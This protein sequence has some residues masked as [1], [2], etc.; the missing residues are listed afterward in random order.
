MAYRSQ[1]NPQVPDN[2]YEDMLR[3]ID[4]PCQQPAATSTSQMMKSMIFSN[5]KKGHCWLLKRN[6]TT[7]SSVNGMV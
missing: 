6:R 1:E 3:C 7:V 4:V 5:L 2:I